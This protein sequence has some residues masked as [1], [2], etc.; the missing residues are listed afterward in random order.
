MH[1]RPIRQYDVGK[2]TRCLE[3]RSSVDISVHIL[4]SGYSY[5]VAASFLAFPVEVLS[6]EYS[7][8]SYEHMYIQILEQIISFKINFSKV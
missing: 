6:N 4:V 7:I 5:S 1:G 3:I 2:Q 8:P